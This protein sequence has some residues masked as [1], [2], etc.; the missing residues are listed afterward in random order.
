MTMM[1]LQR[2]PSRELD[3]VVRASAP[4]TAA[5]PTDLL[6]WDEVRTHALHHRVL[7]RVWRNAAA[8]IPAHHADTFQHIAAANAQLSLRYL[9]RTVEVVQLLEAAGI[10]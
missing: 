2:S 7:P 9:A 8:S 1:A 5:L 4:E 6:D 10:D 3:F